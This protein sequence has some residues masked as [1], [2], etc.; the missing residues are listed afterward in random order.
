[1]L[2]IYAGT[3]GYLDKIPVQEVPRWETSFQQFIREQKH[4]I[5][6]KIDETQQL[7]DDTEAQIK[8]SLVDFQRQYD[9][10]RREEEA[11][12]SPAQPVM[13]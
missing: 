6:Q 5:W 7:D 2:S 12:Q 9:S 8:E 1:M 10:Q 3:K 11:R 13:A 4:E